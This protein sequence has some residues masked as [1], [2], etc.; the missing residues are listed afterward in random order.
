MALYVLDPGLLTTLQDAGR[1]GYERFGVPVSGAMDWFALHAANR[2]VGNPPGAAALEFLSAAPPTLVPGEDIL[3]A[4]GG[5]GFSIEV[6][7]IPIPRWMAFRARA[8]QTV[9]MQAQGVGCWGILAAA[10][11]IDTPPVLGSR[12]T[13]LR[14][15]LGGLEGRALRPTDWLPVGLPAAHWAQLAGSALAECVIPAYAAQVTLRVILGP[16]QNAFTPGAIQTLLESSYTISPNS[17]RMGY[18]LEGPRLEHLPRG[19]DILSEG[20]ALGS[21]QVPGN[22]QPL[23]LLSD[24]QSTGGYTKIATVITAD[25]PLAAQC[26]P[27]QG[28]IRFRAVDVAHAQAHLR[29]QTA[30]LQNAIQLETSAWEGETWI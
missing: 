11:G 20:I 26:P 4:G 30:Q 28:Q 12:A 8:G 29:R 2:L 6:D 15:A 22:G 13:Y 21:L 10:G 18:R 3:L 14:S 5:A 1:R 23:L 17:D 24:R 16:Q 7:G 19:A 27:H 25:L 9:R